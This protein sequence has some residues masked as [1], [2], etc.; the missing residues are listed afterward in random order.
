MFEAYSVAIR[1]SLINGITSELMNI[2]RGF[3][4][5]HGDATKFKRE[6]DAIKFK[7]LAGAAIAGTGFFGL[8]LLGKT[9]PYAK[10]YSRQLALM[11]TLG[12]KQ[13]DIAKVVGQA[14]KTS[15]AV[16]T[17]TAAQNL[18]TFRELRSAFGSDTEGQAHAAM[19]LPVVGRL[20]GVMQS[21]TGRAQEHVGFDMV[22][23][24]ELRTGVM[25][26][27]A[28][29]R[30]SE[31]MSRAI[32]GMGGT[33]TVADFHGAL[34]MG[35]MATNKWSDD[36]AY[37]YLP[38]LMQELKTG[39]GSSGSGGGA[40]SAG[41]MLMSLYQQVHGRMT[42]SSMPLWVEGGLVRPQDVVKNQTGQYQ[43][44]PG[45]VAGTELFEQNPF[46]W[47]QQY[48]R[49]AVARIMA[50][51]HISAES[52]INSMF[53]N[54]NAGFAAYNMYFKAAQYERDKA[55]IGKADGGYTAYQKLLKTDPTLA[56]QALTAQWQNI[57]A[58]I[59]FSIMPTLVSGT[60]KLMGGLRMVS[61][62]MR[63]HPDLTK[64]LVIGFAALSAAMAFGGTVI[65][66]SAAF[67]AIKLALGLFNVGK[68]FG[69]ATGIS[70]IAAA[71]MSIMG[72]SGTVGGE[73]AAIAASI[74]G[75]VGT[76]GLIVLPV[77]AAVLIG[78][79]QNAREAAVLADPGKATPLDKAMLRNRL[80]K[81][82]ALD[83]FLPFGKGA[84]ATAQAQ[85]DRLN[86]RGVSPFIWG[87]PKNHP[88]QVT[89]QVNLDGKAVAK[90]V[91]KHQANAI[92][93]GQMGAPRFDPAA[94][95]PSAAAGFV[96]TGFCGTPG[97]G[98]PPP[99]ARWSLAC[100]ENQ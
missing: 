27:A 56:Q 67:G 77:A 47:I 6:L 75:F 35:K 59:G 5:A 54:R 1:V 42:K 33:V 87:G 79:A 26:T 81:E 91:S 66:L 55:T 98:G 76:L 84:G 44:R 51:E 71:E 95:L 23:A 78:K 70:R 52:A 50:K 85:L 17:T 86:G 41:T 82:I 24:I 10:E 48:L 89:T 83:R 36:F 49:P 61:G 69:L 65:L 32:I 93:P 100:G 4:K 88:V 60:L 43:M 3:L 40:Q 30:N 46:L 63:D 34:K 20:A 15:F 8:S 92:G 2:S 90:V 39:A 96:M 53:S 28:L 22:K 73:L 97:P 12:M 62:W 99:P 31:L 45:S 7:L 74:L 9:L 29:E 80:E 68:L 13:A 37:N 16:P 38:T 58:Q 94:S 18:A 11:N 64:G 72:V 57:L 19:M 21:L 25:T 14:W